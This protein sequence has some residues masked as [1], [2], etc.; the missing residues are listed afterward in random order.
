VTSERGGGSANRSPDALRILTAVGSPI[1]LATALAFY[2]GWVRSQAQAVAFGTDVSV[3]DMSPQDLI[4]RST[5][6]LFFPIILLLL[7]G[8]GL[9]WIE[10]LIRARGRRVGQ[11]L[12]FAWLLVPLGLVLLWLIPPVGFNLLPLLVMV[13]I[14]G[15]AY[16]NLLRRHARGDLSPPRLAN[17]T[18]V[19]ALLIAALF[20]Q[21]ERFARLGGE[22]LAAD[23]QQNLAA[24]L[25]AVTL[26]STARQHIEGPGVVETALRGSD[27]GYQYR[28]EG[29]YL[30]QRSGGKYFL[31]TDGWQERQGRL[32]IFGDTEAIRLEFGP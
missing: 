23:V 31:L 2:F 13:A 17:V 24:R 4:L 27:A 5:N 14:G 18:L 12:Q 19:V 6:I 9:V 30:L 26:L 10:P 3:F 11:V 25:P 7:V 16:G 28:Y 29:L 8:L 32:L 20:W 15:T 21:T 22:A 1:A